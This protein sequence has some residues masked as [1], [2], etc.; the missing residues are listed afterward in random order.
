MTGTEPSGAAGGKSAE[1][2][3]VVAWRDYW[4]APS[5]TFIRDQV[6]FLQ[7]WR[8]V[9]VG[10][11]QYA[12]PLLAAAT[13]RRTPMPSRRGWPAGSQ[14]PGTSGSATSESSVSPRSSSCTRISGPMHSRPAH[15]P[16]RGLAADRDLLRPRCHVPYPVARRAGATGGDSPSSSDADVLI[17]A[18]KYL[19]ELVSLGAHPAKIVIIH[20]ERPSSPCSGSTAPTA[21]A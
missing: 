14:R 12:E 4:L 6:G 3:T 16:A 18:S 19:G 2:P 11:R 9:R 8:A 21:P 1:R 7:R 15:R 17:A 10:R 13:S 5:E 20:P